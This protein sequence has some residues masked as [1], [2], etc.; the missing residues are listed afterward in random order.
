MTISADGLRRV[1]TITD[2]EAQAARN[3]R[4]W[5]ARV[6]A[7]ATTTDADNYVGQPRSRAAGEETSAMNS[8][9]RRRKVNRRQRRTYAGNRAGLAP[10]TDEYPT[11]MQFV[12]LP[13]RTWRANVYIANDGPYMSIYAAN[14]RHAPRRRTID[15]Q[16]GSLPAPPV[17]TD[18]HMPLLIPAGMESDSGDSTLSW[19]W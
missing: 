14:G 11:F 13:I 18:R 9:V 3:H 10:R 1:Q 17:V 15:H 12:D 5:V 7:T 6:I 4:E 16:A 2:R 8:T 19:P